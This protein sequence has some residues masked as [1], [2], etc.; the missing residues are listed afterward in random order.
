VESMT[1]VGDVFARP[2]IDAL[3]RL[4]IDAARDAAS[5]LKTIR[6]VGV[7][8][9]P[10]AK[11]E[12]LEFGDMTLLDTLASTE[13][14][15]V[16]SWETRREG[17]KI[18]TKYTLQP[19]AFLVDEA[20]ERIALGSGKTGMVVSAGILPEGYIGE[21]ADGTTGTFRVIDGKRVVVTGDYARA[22]LDGTLTL[23]GR[24]SSI[25][26]TG[27][28]KVYADEVE[29]VLAQHPAVADVIVAG[30]PDPR[31]GH[32]VGAVVARRAGAMVNEVEL[33]ELVGGELAGYKKP[34]R[35]RFVEEVQRKATG[36][37]DRQWAEALLAENG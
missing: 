30:I 15:R 14:G 32:L 24:G 33:I 31:W 20:G 4:P 37:A 16:A 27:G 6:S 29:G 17:G 9:S 1:I 3:R 23:I 35:I 28:E 26:N 11:A 21:R 36:K 18:V 25:I 19:T 10:D 13:G 7:R 22:E 2:L 8:W 34:R 12:L 5:S